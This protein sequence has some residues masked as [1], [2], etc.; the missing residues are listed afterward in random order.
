M[1]F[2][3]RYKEH[4]SIYINKQGKHLAVY[5]L[6]IFYMVIA[7][8]SFSLAQ[9][10][11][12]TPNNV[13]SHEGG[14]LMLSCPEK[15]WTL[16]PQ[17]AELIS[18]RWIIGQIYNGILEYDQNDQ[19]IPVLAKSLPEKIGEREYL[20][21][22]RTGIK[23]HNQVPFDANDVLFT[24]KRI[25]DPA[26]KCPTRQLFQG[27]QSAQLLS[28]HTI[29]FRL[30]PECPDFV[31]LLTRTEAYPVS[32]ETVKKNSG[33]PGTIPFV[34]TGPF[35]F[36]EWDR[37]KEV[38]LE[39]NYSYKLKSTYLHRI[40]FSFSDQGQ[41]QLREFGS[42]KIEIL[43]D[44]SPKIA[45]ALVSKSYINI[46]HK[47]GQRICQIYLNTERPPFDRYRLRKAVSMGISRREIVGDVFYGFADPARSCIPQW[48]KFF[49]PYSEKQV[50][51]PNHV[52]ALLGE[53]G[54]NVDTP[55]SF[56][57]MFTNSEPFRGIA[58]SIQRQ[59]SRIYINVHLIPLGKMELFDYIYGRN[60]KER[61]Y[62]QAALEDWEDWRGGGDVEQ[63]T[64]RIYHHSAPEYKLG[65]A[66]Y[67]WQEYL[68]QAARECNSEHR[69]LLYSK[70]ISMIDNEI[71]TIYICNPHKIWA[72]R[73]W[74]NG[75]FCNSLG[76][77]LLE[78]VW[79]R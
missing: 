56:S 19:I 34:G 67:S 28:S 11:N 41:N 22:L 18:E 32:M 71:V 44:I 40:V 49:D 31:N 78:N 48:H 68:E 63:F 66:V 17:K 27:I 57:L 30:N 37:D 36:V 7:T 52:L 1:G 29:K 76:D 5:I 55:L 58:K 33:S 64:W 3:L 25:L 62:F 65:H 74:V 10:T 60:D 70:A 53:E 61:N 14:S 54:Y 35:R 21:Q 26:T 42:G 4:S 2:K 51:D 73:V 47:S 15:I 12:T 50:F 43:S 23:F 39:R 75:E 13:I 79:V 9:E 72:S 46:K 45:S 6:F 38:I 77:L 69:E 20:V 24:L 16:D 59:L 8:I